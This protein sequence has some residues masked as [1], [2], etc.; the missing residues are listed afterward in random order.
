MV[1]VEVAVSANR[2][3]QDLH[4]SAIAFMFSPAPSL[5]ALRLLLCQVKVGISGFE[6]LIDTGGAA[7]IWA[8]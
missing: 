6:R 2:E 3:R 4:R 8:V 1:A 5:L 7:E